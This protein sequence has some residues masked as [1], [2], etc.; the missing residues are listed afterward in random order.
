M[1]TEGGPTAPQ[2]LHR[3]LFE[4]PLLWPLMK[5]TPSHKAVYA[6]SNKP[7]ARRVTGQ[8]VVQKEGVGNAGIL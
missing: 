6:P 1:L 2:T 7:A 8:K 4:H 5:L 3:N